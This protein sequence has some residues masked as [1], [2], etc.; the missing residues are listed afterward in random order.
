MA[1]KCRECHI[2]RGP[3]SLC[4]FAYDAHWRPGYG[5]HPRMS[6][7]RERAL[8]SVV[9]FSKYRNGSFNSAPCDTMQ[10][11]Y[12]QS[13]FLGE[14]QRNISTAA[15]LQRY[16]G[17]S[18]SLSGR[19]ATLGASLTRSTVRAARPRTAAAPVTH[20]AAALMWRH[21]QRHFILSLLHH[22][23][24]PSR[25][26]RSRSSGGVTSHAHPQPMSDTDRPRTMVR[27]RVSSHRCFA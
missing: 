26:V 11:Q 20:E 13:T 2:V 17:H 14:H 12:T 22:G 23:C 25:R 27:T 19:T 10:A 3:S 9:I 4:G 21:L 8:Q 6:E 1:R 24:P 5:E 15:S 7:H 16:R 18:S